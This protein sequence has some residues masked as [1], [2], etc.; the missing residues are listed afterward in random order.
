MMGSVQNIE[1]NYL[2]KLYKNN[3]YKSRRAETALATRGSFH[4]SQFSVG[5]ER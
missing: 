2:L 4:L 3:G 1:V 5:V